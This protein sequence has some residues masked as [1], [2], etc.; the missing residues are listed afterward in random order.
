MEMHALLWKS[1][2]WCH[3][4][5]KSQAHSK[6]PQ[7]DGLPSIQSNKQNGHC[8]RRCSSRSVKWFTPH[9]DLFATHLN[10]KVALYVS[11]APDQHAWYIDALNIIWS[12]LSAY[13]YPSTA[14]LHRVI[15]K[16]GNVTASS[17]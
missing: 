16:S 5:L 2:T 9:V 15:Q 12:G 17:L 3:H 8:I 7:C 14:L 13:A 4:Y 11:P 1:M 6:M 10:L